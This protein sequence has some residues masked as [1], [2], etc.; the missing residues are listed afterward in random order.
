[1]NDNSALVSVIIPTYGGTKEL[2]RAIT[3]VLNQTYKNFELLVV[4]DNNPGTPERNSTKSIISL[5]S[6]QRLKYICHEKNKNGSAARNTGIKYSNGKYI[7]FLD[8][9]DFYLPNRLKL[10]VDALEKFNEYDAVLC[11]VI[12]CTNSGLLGV[13]YYYT[14]SG[15]FKNQLLSREI[16]MGSGS[17][18]F[19]TKN[20]VT[21]LGGFDED[22][23]RLQDDEFMVRFYQRYKAYAIEPVLIV[24][25]CNGISN[26][27]ELGGL[28]NNKMQFFTKY[29]ADIDELS[30]KEHNDFLNYHYTALLNSAMFSNNL[31]LRKE[32]WNKAKEL[33]KITSKERLKFFLGNKKVGRFILFIFSKINYKGKQF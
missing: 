8:D 16:I 22:F 1:M 28:Y 7:C 24:K 20:A 19:V 27:P 25:S 9:D 14:E 17:N 13:R 30:E 3:S 4:D 5:F 6:D 12:D 2:E 26:E 23:R 32:V 21:S 33:R 18:I 11:G 10:S 15:S 29:Q 31:V